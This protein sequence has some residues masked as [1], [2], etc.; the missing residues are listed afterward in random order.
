VELVL[1]RTLFDDLLNEIEIEG[2]KPQEAFS[3]RELV[4][5]GYEGLSKIIKKQGYQGVIALFERKGF[6][7]K[8][9]TLQQYLFQYRSQFKQSLDSTSSAESIGEAAL[10][11]PLSSSPVQPPAPL[12]TTAGE[13]VQPDSVGAIASKGTNANKGTNGVVVT[14]ANKGTNKAVVNTTSSAALVIPTPEATVT[15]TSVGTAIADVTPST[16]ADVTHPATAEVGYQDGEGERGREE[17]R[18]K[19][20]GSVAALTPE[21]SGG[22]VESLG[23]GHLKEGNLSS[24]SLEVNASSPP[25]AATTVLSPQ[26]E[27]VTDGD[28]LPS[29]I[30]QPTLEAKVKTGLQSSAA[31]AWDFDKVANHFLLA[32]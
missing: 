10:P 32:D 14:N 7:I 29:K 11:H 3:L 24:Q 25:A 4:F 22:C 13:G 8:L 18:D 9:K 26:G 15:P 31:S 23:D 2:D 12:T 28:Q 17:E 19:A 30:A 6:P 21:L 16:T 1:T 27:A 5:A 20:D